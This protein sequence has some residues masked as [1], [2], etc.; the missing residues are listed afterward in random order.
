MEKVVHKTSMKDHCEAKE[1][2]RYWLS[3]TPQERI[4]AVEFL[5]KQVYGDLQRLPGIARVVHKVQR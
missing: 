5:R 1:N 3:R 4:A 2:L